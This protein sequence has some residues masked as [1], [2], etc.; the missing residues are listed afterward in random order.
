N[1]ALKLKPIAS[2]S[3]FS[4][5]SGINNSKK[6]IDKLLVPK[7]ESNQKPENPVNGTVSSLNVC[8]LT[9]K[10]AVDTNTKEDKFS[11]EEDCLAAFFDLSIDVSSEKSND[12]N[13][14]RLAESTTNKSKKCSKIQDNNLSSVKKSQAGY[15]IKFN[16]CP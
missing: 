6:N 2:V 9:A 12:L 5:G 11:L 3:G 4:D 8:P 14:N 1:G 7:E 16:E 13:V 10:K 15:F